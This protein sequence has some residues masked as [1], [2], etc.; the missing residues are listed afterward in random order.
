MW[1]LE[2]KRPENRSVNKYRKTG[3]KT[4]FKIKENMAKR[5]ETQLEKR[6]EHGQ[7]IIK[8]T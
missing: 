4:N 2:Y 7:N 1:K 6:R 5:Q 3:F 8:S